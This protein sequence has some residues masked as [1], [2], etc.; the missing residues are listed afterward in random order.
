[1]TAPGKG[2]K[3]PN[4]AVVWEYT[5]DD[6]KNGF[7]LMLSSVAVHDGLVY[8]ADFEG[9]LHCIDAKT[10][11]RH[12]WHDVRGRVW[13][14]PLVADGKVYAA[15]ND[16]DVLVFAAGKTKQFLAKNEF[17]HGIMASPVFANGVLYAM[18]NGH[19]HAIAVPA[20]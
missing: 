13:G 1:M 6:P 15:T 9:Y 4:S 18:T 7:H 19:L 3:N 20:K 16:G 10:G 8:A 12:W 11:E 17:N 5:R 14:H 2:K